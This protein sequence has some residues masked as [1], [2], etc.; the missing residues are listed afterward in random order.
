[1]IIWVL[2]PA[3]I[4]VHWSLMMPWSISFLTE[5]RHV[6]MKALTTKAL[7]F[8]FVVGLFKPPE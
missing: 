5:L 1:M 3:K 8:A 2:E 7:V 4:K 6:S